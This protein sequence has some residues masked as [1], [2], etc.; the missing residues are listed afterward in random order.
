MRNLNSVVNMNL[1]GKNTAQLFIAEVPKK[2]NDMRD[3]NQESKDEN[4]PALG[5]L[6]LRPWNRDRATPEAPTLGTIGRVLKKWRWSPQTTSG[7]SL[8]NT[9]MQYVKQPPR[10]IAL[11]GQ[12][13][14]A[15]R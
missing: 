10:D 8:R 15:V 13:L 4:S 9:L 11:G 3:G 5:L 6:K 14:T 7:K 2:N 12:Y 1:K